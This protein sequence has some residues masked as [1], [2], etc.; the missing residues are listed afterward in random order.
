MAGLLGLPQAS[1]ENPDAGVHAV[2]KWLVSEP[3][4]LLVIDNV[5]APDDVKDLLP[6]EPSGHVLLTSRVQYLEGIGIFNPV[7]LD[8]LSTDDAVAFLIKRCTPDE[9]LTLGDA[10]RMSAVELAT[11]LGCLPLALEQA[12]AYV[13]VNEMMFA[14]YL[15]EYRTLR[16]KLLDEQSPTAGAYQDSVRTTWQKS[17]DKVREMSQASA[18]LL[19]ACAFLASDKIPFEFVTGGSEKL[20]EN[21]A[22]AIAEASSPMLGLNRLLK[23]LK[24]YSLIKRDSGTRTF[25]VHRMVQAVVREALSEQ[26]RVEWLDRSLEALVVV[27]PGQGVPEWTRCERFVV[28][29]L[30]STEIV[31]GKSL[32]SAASVLNQMSIYFQEHADYALAEYAQESSLSIRERVLGADHLD[33]ASSLNNLAVL[34]KEMGRYA[35]ALPLYERSLSIRERVLGVDHCDVATT[36]NNLAELYRTMGWRADALELHARALSIRERVLGVDHPHVATSL[37][38][39]AALYKEMGYQATALPL[40]ERSLSIRERVLGVDHPHVAQS[41]NNLAELYCAMGRHGDALELHAR[42]L[43]IRERVL[44]VDHPHV[45]T[46]LNNLANLYLTLG[47][48][49]DALELHAR[50]LSIRERVL[51]MDHPDVA[52]SL[53]NIGVHYRELGRLQEAEEYLRRGLQTFEAVLGSE[54]LYVAIAAEHLAYLLTLT[55]RNVEATSLRLRAQAICKAHA[56]RNK[57]V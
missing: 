1:P 15:A 52:T 9:G 30:T 34:Y 49:G 21:V 38:N 36:L 44:G 2:L 28:H 7:P 22:R 17:F 33:V 57:L 50:S 54:H 3:D 37:N 39:L 51:G 46:S 6:S 20:G 48:H 10:E 32:Q 56:E 40:Y 45:A 53:V 8:E 29:W 35:D 13:R 47:R 25:D 23:P 16:L 4:Y 55:G 18:D 43:S 26:E 11:E 12:G 31:E 27:Y 14:D 42:A 19:T 5:D 24:A 41:L